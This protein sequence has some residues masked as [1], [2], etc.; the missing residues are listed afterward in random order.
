MGQMQARLA[1]NSCPSQIEGRKK[2]GCLRADWKPCRK[3]L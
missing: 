1:W 3:S 2:G